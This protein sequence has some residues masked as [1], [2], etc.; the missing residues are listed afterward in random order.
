MDAPSNDSRA[1]LVTLQQIAFEGE[2]WGAEERRP[3]SRRRDATFGQYAANCQLIRL[4][5]FV[6]SLAGKTAV[7]I[8]DGRGLEASYLT[9]H[10]LRVTATDLTP[11]LLPSLCESGWFD[12]WRPENGELL[13]F[14]TGSF[15][16]GLVRAG[17]HH[18]PC[19]MLGFYELLRVSRE[20]II[21][22]EAHDSAVLRFL[23]RRVF[24]SRD[25]EP[26]GNYVYRFTAR[27]IEKACLGLDLPGFAL[28]TRLLMWR[29]KYERVRKGSAPYL[30][31]R[32][33][34]SCVDFA[35]GRQGNVFGVVVFKTPPDD[36][37]LKLLRGSGFK[38]Y[39]LPRNPHLS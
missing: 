18:L 22:L 2:A 29:R 26:S 15:H 17:L 9:A 20:G 21:L 25:W 6:Q 10:G 5:P 13:S 33:F 4:E 16:W 12:K 35:L 7:T 39:R 3:Y 28:Q 32:A 24:T 14:E 30:V 36:R 27:E 19:P 37:Q 31:L 11:N 8:C 34:W 23:R 38:Y 1:R